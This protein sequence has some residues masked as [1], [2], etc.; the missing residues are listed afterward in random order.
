LLV[1]AGWRILRSTQPELAPLKTWGEQIARRRGKRIAAVALA[2]RIAGVLFAMW[3]DERE[4]T[5]ARVSVA[6]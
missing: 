4:F 3:R 6:A 2:R 1:E 5:G